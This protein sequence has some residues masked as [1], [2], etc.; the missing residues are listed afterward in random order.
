MKLNL[1]GKVVLIT[2]GSKGLG[3]AC[4]RAFAGEGAKVAIASRS[5]ENLDKALAALRKDGFD[6]VA[7]RADLAQ[8]PEAKALVARTEQQLGPVDVLVNS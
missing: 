6:V 7:I 3:L 1:E 8:A 5:Q 2:G 4:A